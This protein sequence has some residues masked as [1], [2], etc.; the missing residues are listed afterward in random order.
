LQIADTA[1]D[2]EGLSHRPQHEI[3]GKEQEKEK[4]AADHGGAFIGVHGKKAEALAGP[5]DRP[6]GGIRGHR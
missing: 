2:A 5:T 6:R 4:E 1:G 3:A